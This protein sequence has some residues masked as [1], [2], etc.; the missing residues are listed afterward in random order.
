M[1]EGIL[2]SLKSIKILCLVLLSV[3]VLSGCGTNNESKPTVSQATGSSPVI[4]N[5]EKPITIA[6]SFYPMYI[7]TLNVAKDIPNVNKNRK[8]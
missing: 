3:L 8:M 6:A 4:N 1:K 5:T 7:L 2:M